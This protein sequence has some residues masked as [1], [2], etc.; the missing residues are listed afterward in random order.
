MI[1]S[2]KLWNLL[3]SAVLCQTNL[4]TLYSEHFTPSQYSTVSSLCGG[5]KL[6][7][8]MVVRVSHKTAEKASVAKRSANKDTK[9]ENEAYTY[10]LRGVYRRRY[11][12][13]ITSHDDLCDTKMNGMSFET[14]LYTRLKLIPPTRKVFTAS[15][16]FSEI[17]LRQTIEH[18][19][20]SIKNIK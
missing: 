6:L 1:F 20:T 5:G 16:Y 13:T 18:T 4:A 8:E 3:Y 12:F 11:W 2:K 14:S 9:R 7:N 15:K 19:I 17:S 10:L